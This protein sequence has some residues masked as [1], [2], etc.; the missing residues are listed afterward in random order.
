[1]ILRFPMPVFTPVPATTFS[2]KVA[3]CGFLTGTRS[4]Y[5]DDYAPGEISWN[6]ADP[7]KAF[8]GVAVWEGGVFRADRLPGGRKTHDIYPCTGAVLRNRDPRIDLPEF[9]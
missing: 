3:L 5:Y 9:Q 8:S 6:M 4:R 7:T 1:M 2:G